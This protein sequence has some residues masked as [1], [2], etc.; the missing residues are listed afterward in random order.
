MMHGDPLRQI[1]AQGPYEEVAGSTDAEMNADIYAATFMR[2]QDHGIQPVLGFVCAIPVAAGDTHLPAPDRAKLI[3]RIYGANNRDNP[4][5][6]VVPPGSNTLTGQIQKVAKAAMDK[7]QTIRGTQ[8][9]GDHYAALVNLS[10]N[11]RDVPGEI[12]V[13]ANKCDYVISLRKNDDPD[14]TYD[15]IVDAATLAL[16]AWNSFEIPNNSLYP[17]DRKEH[18]WLEHE[19]NLQSAVI[20]LA[21][22]T[23]TTNGDQFLTLRIEGASTN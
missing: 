5:G 10:V 8:Q 9:E 6:L 20:S 21:I 4:C 16:P 23:N 11:G 7:F 22:T 2:Y 3:A 1:S 14:S 12:D 17:K 19:G 15:T 13:G 18:R